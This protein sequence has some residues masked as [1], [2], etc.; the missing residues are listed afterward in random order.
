MD[1]ILEI[2]SYP[3]PLLLLAVIPLANLNY[4]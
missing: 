2:A 3:L 4:G 1:A